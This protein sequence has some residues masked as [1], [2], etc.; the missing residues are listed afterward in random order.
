MN[1]YAAPAPAWGRR[2]LLYSIGIFLG[3]VLLASAWL[4]V[5]A[6]W[7]APE[8]AAST[9]TWIVL[10]AL[11]TPF[12][13]LWNNPGEQRTRLHRFAEFAYCWVLLSGLT[14][15]AFELPWFFMDLAGTIHNAGRAP[16]TER[17]SRASTQE[18]ASRV[19]S[20]R[21][22]RRGAA[23]CGLAPCRR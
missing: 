23:L 6:G 18:L 19:R 10:V 2:K 20:L 8:R 12:A 14:Q 16:A 22:K 11:F 1:A 5:L 4:G 21:G 15:T 13:A 7:F 3:L 9:M 17:L